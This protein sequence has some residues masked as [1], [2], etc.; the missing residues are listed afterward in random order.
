MIGYGADITATDR[1]NR[2]VL[3]YAADSQCT[4]GA[5]MIL[6][7]GQRENTLHY[8]INEKEKHLGAE[9]CFLVRGETWSITLKKHMQ[10][11]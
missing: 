2:S 3:H 11:P 4:E 1:R 6:E 7:K 9:Q 10:V 5:E 8:I